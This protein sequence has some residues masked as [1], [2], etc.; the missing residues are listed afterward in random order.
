[1]IR[2]I[3][4]VRAAYRDALDDDLNLPQGVGLFFELVR[5]A[6]TALDEMKV[7]EG[8]RKALLAFIEEVD[9]HLDVMGGE[10][11]ALAEE[12]ERMIAEREAA[13]RAKDFA[14]ADRIRD[15]LKHRGIALE[16]SRDGVR[17]RRMVRG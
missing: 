11:T 17:W 10:E 16:D 14:S 9:G 1:M 5:E 13:R 6:N 7:G 12:V 2:R 8:G 4:E 3:G 15:E